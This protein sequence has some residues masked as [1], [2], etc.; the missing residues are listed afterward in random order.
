MYSGGCRTVE[1]RHAF[2]KISHNAIDR[3][4]AHTT[5]LGKTL[6]AY[7]PEEKRK[8]RLLFSDLR[9]YTRDEND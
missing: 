1:I 2:C 7:R 9:T 5:A 4:P 3:L 8:E 6:L